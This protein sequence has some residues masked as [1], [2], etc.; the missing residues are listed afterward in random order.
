SGSPVASRLRALGG[1]VTERLKGA[2]L[3]GVQKTLGVISTHF[4]VD[5]EVVSGGYVVADDLDDD[6]AL[7]VVESADAATS[8]PAA[9]LA[10]IFE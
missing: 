6:A 9:T 5:L 4:V 3:L 7:A 10:G 1:C 2:L 8:A